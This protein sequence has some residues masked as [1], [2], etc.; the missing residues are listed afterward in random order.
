MLCCIS[1]KRGGEVHPETDIEII[2]GY[3]R[4]ES[5]F[6]CTHDY[7]TCLLGFIPIAEAVLEKCSHMWPRAVLCRISAKR[8]GE[9][10]P[11]TDIEIIVGYR[12]SES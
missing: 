4:C 10:H 1:A 2:V 5:C 3:R 8:G 6:I 11:E 9:V 12:R 7:R